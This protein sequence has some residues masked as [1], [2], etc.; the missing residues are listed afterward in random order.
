MGMLARNTKIIIMAEI[1]FKNNWKKKLS[2]FLIQSPFDV[3]VMVNLVEQDYLP[4]DLCKW[5]DVKFIGFKRHQRNHICS[6]VTSTTGSRIALFRGK[7][8]SDLSVAQ[9]QAAI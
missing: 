6:V 7:V 8:L 2:Y 1:S 4:W 9:F 3:S 5:L